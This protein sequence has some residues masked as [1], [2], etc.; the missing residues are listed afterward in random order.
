MIKISFARRFSL[1]NYF[2]LLQLGDYLDQFT[3]HLLGFCP[4]EYVKENRLASRCYVMREKKK[5]APRFLVRTNVDSTLMLPMSAGRTGTVKW[6]RVFAEM[7]QAVEEERRTD[8]T[9]K[10]PRSSARDF[11]RQTRRPAVTG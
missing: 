10:S 6:L 8:Q 2:G 11:G 7:R 3:L 4:T 1:S 5:R 9:W